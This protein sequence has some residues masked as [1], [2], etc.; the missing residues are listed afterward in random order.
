MARKKSSRRKPR[1]KKLRLPVQRHLGVGLERAE[2]ISHSIEQVQRVNIQRVV[3]Q[4]A[5]EQKPAA[6]A[7]GFSSTG[8]F[9]D[10]GLVKYLITDELIQAPVEREQLECAPGQMI[11]CLQRGM[12]L[13]RRGKVPVVVALR[14]GRFSSDLPI[15]DVVAGC[16]EAARD[17]LQALLDEA[18]RGSVYRGRT[19]VLEADRREAVS[20]RFQTLRP[21]ERE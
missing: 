1:V 6:C 9:A 18:Q 10:D 12:F 7:I 16:R 19:I 14:P 21:T 20:V 13:L 3:D 8:Y 2:C 17:T 15:L 5:A 4:W 11:D